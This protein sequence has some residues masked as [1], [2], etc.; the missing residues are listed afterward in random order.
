MS[1]TSG[2]ER[3]R[4]EKAAASRQTIKPEY[5]ETTPEAAS[6]RVRAFLKAETARLIKPM[7]KRSGKPGKAA[8]KY[9]AN[10]QPVTTRPTLKRAHNSD[11]FKACQ[12]R[13]VWIP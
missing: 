4:R 9:M 11:I 12:M 2:N 10:Q 1:G 5:W 6:K 13:K 7:P 8:K 3:R